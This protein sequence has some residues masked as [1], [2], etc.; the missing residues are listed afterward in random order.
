[1]ATATAPPGGI[2]R[3][4][5]IKTPKRLENV[6]VWASTTV[7]LVGLMAIS[8][9]P[10]RRHINGSVRQFWEDEAMPTGIA[11]HRRSAIP[12]ILRHDVS[13]PLFYLLLHF[14]I[15]WFGAREGAAPSLSLLFAL[16]TIP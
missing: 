8:A 7:F 9:F 14:W 15:G 11:S 1:M 2:P 6:P 10:G 16:S 13:P 3:I 5:D 12:G 4:R